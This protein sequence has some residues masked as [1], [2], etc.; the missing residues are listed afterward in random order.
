MIVSR[1]VAAAFCVA[2][3]AGCGGDNDVEVS[4]PGRVPRPGAF[5]GTTSSGSEITIDV[6]SIERIG[7]TCRDTP[8]LQVF[9][10]PAPILDDGRFDV[11]FE[12]A[13]RS[14]RVTGRFAN[15]DTCNGRIEDEQH[16][17][18]DTFVV[19]RDLAPAAG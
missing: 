19:T 16:Q 18:D 9:S 10:P 7:F 11:R 8:V 1:I 15:D 12:S 4:G 6:G 14:F 13:G 17:C 2:L 5:R 3:I